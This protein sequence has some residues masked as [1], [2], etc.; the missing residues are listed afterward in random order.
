[1]MQNF[2]RVIRN[3]S[4]VLIPI[5]VVILLATVLIAQST[6]LATRSEILPLS[7]FAI[8]LT[9]SSVAFGWSRV[10]YLAEDTLLHIFRAGVDM[11][12]ASLLALTAAALGWLSSTPAIASSSAY[13]VLLGVHWFFLCLCFALFTIAILQLMRAVREVQRGDEQPASDREPRL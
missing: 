3:I 10:P 2:R 12:V 11:F 6:E 1:M 5:G 8:L 7:S 9:F 13:V 4:I